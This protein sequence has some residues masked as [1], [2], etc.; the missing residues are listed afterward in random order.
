MRYFYECSLCDDNC[1]LTFKTDGGHSKPDVC[2]WS[3]DKA[4]WVTIKIHDSQMEIDFKDDLR[5]IIRKHS[6]S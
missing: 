1:I 2:P 6:R 3:A 4:E 5:N